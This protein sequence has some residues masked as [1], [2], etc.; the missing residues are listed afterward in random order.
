MP[1]PKPLIIGSEQEIAEHVIEDL[2]QEFDEVIASGNVL[3]TWAGTHWIEITRS[4]IFSFIK[5]YDGFPYGYAGHQRVIRITNQKVESTEKLIVRNRECTDFFRKPTVGI[6]CLNG[7]IKLGEEGAELVPHHKKHL[8][9]HVL[10]VKWDAQVCSKAHDGSL[11][12][13]Y[14]EGVFRDDP[15]AAQKRMVLAEIA[16]VV[17]SG[18]ATRLSSPKAV[19][20]YGP[21]A[22]NGKSQF[23]SLLRGLVPD[24]AQVT[25]NPSHLADDR[26]IALLDGAWLVS[27]SEIGGKAIA[28]EALKAAVTGDPM[29]GRPLYKA[30]YTVRPKALFV[31]STNSLPPFTSGMDAGVR[32]RLLIVAFDRVIPEDER[33]ERIGDLIAEHELTLV[34]SW[35]IGGALR[36][37]HQRGFTELKSSNDVIR[38]WVLISDPFEC[39]LNDPMAVAITGREEDHPT[40]REAFAAFRKW[41]ELENLRNTD[42]GKQTRFTQRLRELASR[43]VHVRHS[44][45]GNRVHGLKLNPG[46]ILSEEEGDKS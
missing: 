37:I 13:Q 16:G 3:Y 8:N 10:P 5:A 35:A 28:S 25:L 33:I 27:A 7:F 44:N 39:W 32:R 6:P 23:Q 17:L 18:Y 40:T 26:S 1:P 2:T 34:L 12:S 15:E 31:Y 9:R 20:L 36:A 38:E 29:P 4:Q 43:G 42:I 21:S 22:A 45:R 19:I 14:L 24:S 46:V 30:G 41:G 11:L